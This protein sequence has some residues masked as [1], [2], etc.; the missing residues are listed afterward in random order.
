MN[1]HKLAETYINSKEVKSFQ[2]DEW[3]SFEDMSYHTAVNS[4]E[5]CVRMVEAIDQAGY[6][7]VPK[8]PDSKMR[9]AGINTYKASKGCS[10]MPMGYDEELVGDMYKA[11]TK[12][13]SND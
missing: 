4:I 3:V 10:L 2:G 5:A 7:I 13:A 11:M 8:E 1:A 9:F 12:V 6:Q